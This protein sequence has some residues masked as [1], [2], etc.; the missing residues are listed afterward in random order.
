MEKKFQKN[1]IEIKKLKRQLIKCNDA[2]QIQ[3]VQIKRLKEENEKNNVALYS[4]MKINFRMG[5]FCI[6]KT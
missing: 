1:N 3:Q 4:N 6:S 2:L 5:R